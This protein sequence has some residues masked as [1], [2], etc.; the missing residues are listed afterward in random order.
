MPITNSLHA[1]LTVTSG[2]KVNANI[3]TIRQVGWR[4]A[5]GFGHTPTCSLPWWGVPY[6]IPLQQ[7]VGGMRQG[8][9]GEEWHVPISRRVQP[10]HQPAGVPQRPF[11]HDPRPDLLF[12]RTEGE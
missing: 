1:K 2:E 12:H 6:P 8:V 7:S 4:V 11:S 3:L 5:A 9:S 10:Q